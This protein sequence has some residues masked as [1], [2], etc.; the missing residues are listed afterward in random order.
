LPLL[1]AF[2]AL[3]LVHVVGDGD[4]LRAVQV[5]GERLPLRLGPARRAGAPGFRERYDVIDVDVGRVAPGGAV[6]RAVPTAGGRVAVVADLHTGAVSLEDFLAGVAVV[7]LVAPVRELVAVVAVLRA[8][9]LHRQLTQHRGGGGRTR[10]VGW[11]RH[12]R[13]ARGGRDPGGEQD[14]GAKNGQCA[15]KRE[16]HDVPLLPCA[17]QGDGDASWVTGATEKSGEFAN[18]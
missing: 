14:G 7:P 1:R 16:G 15:A 4:Q 17:R 5:V 2:V 12:R 6:V 11:L 8:V 18:W 10:D 3:G 9:R 13:P